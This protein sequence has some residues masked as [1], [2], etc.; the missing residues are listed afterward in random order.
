MNASGTIGFAC[1]VC[2]NSL[3]VT[4]SQCLGA[5]PGPHPD[6]EFTGE[7]TCPRCRTRYVFRGSHA[8]IVL[9]P[10]QKKALLALV[11]TPIV[12]NPA[13]RRTL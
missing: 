4:G 11:A 2:E 13:P 8:R 10:E 5:P 12:C 9:S 1:D 7:T 3:T 6:S